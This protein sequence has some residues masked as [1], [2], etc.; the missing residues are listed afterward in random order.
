MLIVKEV[1]PGSVVTDRVIV[2]LSGVAVLVPIETS[3]PHV[4]LDIPIVE[5]IVTMVVWFV[6][7][8]ET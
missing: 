5:L 4:I 1:D 6:V 7:C 3:D 2:L 8:A